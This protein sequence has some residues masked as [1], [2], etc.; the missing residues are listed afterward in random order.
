MSGYKNYFKNHH[1]LAGH[2]NCQR[3]KKKNLVEANFWAI[4]W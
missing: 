2:S 1:S 4:I 3:V